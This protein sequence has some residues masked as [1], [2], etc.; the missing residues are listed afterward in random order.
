MTGNP[1]LLGRATSQTQHSPPHRFQVVLVVCLRGHG[2]VGIGRLSAGQMASSAIQGVSHGPKPMQV[3]YRI[4]SFQA[5]EVWSTLPGYVVYSGSFL[6]F[7][8]FRRTAE[9][10]LGQLQACGD[11]RKLN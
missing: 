2:I 8:A 3:L 9:N 6:G 5:S 4:Q 10:I 11:A 7:K 1:L